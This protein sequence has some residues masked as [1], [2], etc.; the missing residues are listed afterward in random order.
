M[1]LTQQKKPNII[2]ILADDLGYSD[3]GCYGGDIDTP[4]LDGL[5][6]SGIRFTRFYNSARCCPSRASLL[7]GLHP[8]QTG[9][10]AMV[11]NA[12]QQ[13][14]YQGE[15][16][17]HCVTLAEVLQ[18]A[19][20]QTYMTGKWHVTYSWDGSDKSNWPLQRGFNKYFGTIYGA[21]SYFDPRMLVQDNETTS[22]SPAGF[23]YTDAISD[24]SVR[25]IQEHVRE[26]GDD[27][28]FM[29]V[30]YTAPHWPLH[31]KK[32]DISK[33]KGKFDAGWGELRREKL[34]RMSSLG[35][36][37]DRWDVDDRGA[38]ISRWKS[39]ENK[40]WELKRMEVYAAMVDCMDKG[41][42]RILQELEE[43]GAKE[44]TLVIFLSDNG[45][46]AETW[47]ASNPWA[48]NFGPEFT[49][50]G[51]RVDYSNDGSTDPGPPETYHSY[52][53]GWAHYSNTPFK[54]YKSGTYE[55]GISSPMI[56]SWPGNIEDQSAFRKQ[57]C[58]IIDI[59][60]TLLDVA[61]ATYPDLYRGFSVIPEEGESLVGTIKRNKSIDRASYYV[62]HIG[63]RSLID[64]SGFK[65]VKF[66]NKPW[67][68]Y[69]LEEDRAET[70]EI[71]DKMPEK[72]RDL[73]DRWERWAWRSNVLPKPK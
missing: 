37:D 16:G 20:Y 19:G 12:S 48:A 14:G 46:C 28:F 25:F 23:Y 21:G 59:M 64:S 57:T 51:K 54:G 17:R 41:I 27:P 40:A 42:G 26:H 52:G 18:L 49:R 61:E 47:P 33:Y 10:G 8:H 7:T 3:I 50:D 24:S 15:I 32:S 38:A 43:S 1:V 39:V 11:E 67:E 5:A 69:Q 9:L 29:Y 73:A 71:A 58:G 72:A 30:A 66:H 55:G 44:N 6:D 65:V 2:L 31:A 34:K 56:V 53:P 68:L 45:A 4:N 63:R 60:P 35:L 62:E 22:I 13:A 70:T 36:I